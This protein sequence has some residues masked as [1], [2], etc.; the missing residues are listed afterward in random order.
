MNLGNVKQWFRDNGDYTHRLNYDLNEHSIVFDL[1]GYEGWFVEQITN[2]YD[3]FV[4]CFEPLPEFSEK[5]NI[6]FKDNNK[7]K[8]FTKGISNEVKD[9]VIYLND[10]ATSRNIKTKKSVKIKLTRLDKIMVEENINFIDLLKINIEGDE[11]DVLEYILNN[12]LAKNIDNIQVQ[13]HK[14]GDNYQERYDRIKEG[15][16][17]THKLTYL[18]PFVWENWKLK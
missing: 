9:S 6:K 10:D 17:K 12:N 14:I 15:L 18:Y 13:F 5:I 11:Y 16:E 2:K 7:V 1:G 8:V 4:Y 3:S